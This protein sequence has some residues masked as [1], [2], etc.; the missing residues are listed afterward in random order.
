MRLG[1]LRYG[2]EVYEVSEVRR[3]SQVVQELTAERTRAILNFCFKD[4]LKIYQAL[5]CLFTHRAHYHRREQL[6]N[7]PDFHIIYD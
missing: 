1:E 7:S 3:E 5:F 4:A 2:A 6:K